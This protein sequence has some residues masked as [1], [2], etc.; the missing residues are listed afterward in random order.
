MPYT[1]SLPMTL[2]IGGTAHAAAVELPV[3]DP[4]SGE[5]FAS[6]PDATAEHLDAAVAAARGALDSWWRCGWDKRR[7]KLLEFAEA[8]LE[9][10][11][12]IA[13]WLVHEQG[14]PL[15]RAVG[16]VNAAAAR[17]RATVSLEMPVR[18]LRDDAEYR[19]E[20]HRRPLGVVGA[21][22]PWNGP[23][24]LAMVKVAQALYAGNTVV[25]K[26]SPYTPLATLLLGEISR[27]ILPAGVFNVLSGGNE[28]GRWMTEHPG[29]DKISFTGSVRTGKQ[30]MASA[31]GTLKRLTLEL[32]GNDAAIVLDDANVQEVAP[33][34]FWAAFGNSGQVCMAIKRVYAQSRVY[35]PLCQALAAIAAQVRLG[36]GFEPGVQLGPLQNRAQFDFVMGLIADTRTVPGARFLAGGK[37]LD[38]PGYFIEPTI[39][40]DVSDGT[41]VVDEEAFGPLLP[42][43]RFDDVDDAIARANQSR[44]GLGG[45]VWSSDPGKAAELAQRL[46]VGTAWVNE[47]AVTA[48]DAPFGGSKE[49]GIGHENASMGLEGYM[50]SFVVK[51]PHSQGM[52][53]D[54]AA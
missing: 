43:L 41:R 26:P 1:R 53:E 32:G 18:T 30:I 5:T 40:C 44:L 52:V 22:T 23:V 50:E 20:L 21:I 46:E 16:E 28:L 14:K 24:L 34:I 47:H 49:S 8:I 9:R 35:G 54:A 36:N 42:V 27:G 3:I 33:R 11:D 37:A 17:L 15:A 29:I 51:R 38:R 13:W 25:L 45:S 39:V 48:A 31:A 10:R 2:T 19:I 6:C 4:S 7:K 12:E